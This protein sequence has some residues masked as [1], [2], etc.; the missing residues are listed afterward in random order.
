M[1]VQ[2]REHAT[3]LQITQSLDAVK[4]EFEAV[5]RERDMYKK[6]KEELE[7]KGLFTA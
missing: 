2:T 6:Q 7:C 5:V 3:L 1:M 4:S